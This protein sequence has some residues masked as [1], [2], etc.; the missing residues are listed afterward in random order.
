MTHNVIIGTAGHV[1][2][3]KTWLIKA[4]TGVDTDRLAEEKKRGITIELGFAS[5]PNDEGL[6]IGIIDVPGH[7]K[8]VK[9][10]LAGIGGIDLVLLIIGLDEG[11]MPQTREHFEILKMLRIPKGILVFTKSDLAEE[12]WAAVVEEDAR[13]LVKGSFLEGAPSVRVSALTGENISLLKQMILDGVR[14]TA[15]RRAAPELFRMPVDR[16]FTMEGFGTVA[17]GTLMEGSAAVGEEIMIYPKGQTVRIRGIQNHNVREMEA[18]A[19]QRTA[20][21]LAARKEELDRGDVLARPGG[22]IPGMMADAKVRLFGD[23]KRKLKNNALVHL[24]FGAAQVVAKAVLLDRDVI[25]AGQEAYVQFRFQEPQVMKYGDRF[26]IRF[27]SPV[28]T[29]GGGEFLSAAAEKHR[30]NRPEVLEGLKIRESGTPEERAAEEVRCCS[31]HFPDRRELSV[32]LNCTEEEAAM[33]LEELKKKK[34]I[35]SLGA[36][37]YLH[38]D[39]WQG[40]AEFAEKTVREFHR[41]NPI[42]PGMEREELK[43]R[44]GQRYQAGPEIQELLVNELRKR[45]ALV[46]EGSAV[47][48]ERFA[49]SYEGELLRMKAEI[50]EVY[51]SAGIAVPGSSEM[52]RR[53]K[54]KKMVKQILADLAKQ[55]ILVKVNPDYYME[56]GAWERALQVLRDKIASDGQITLAE[57]RDLLST[58]RKYSQMLLESFDA[59]K[60]TKMVGEAGEEARILRQ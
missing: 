19:G 39:F 36:D 40:I 27:Y 17:T 1:D 58:S 31:G 51:R 16:V 33:L 44:L 56:T 14:D 18:E 50:E 13:E 5:L 22:L 12:D 42:L 54:D 37:R 26:I 28:E 43:T 32:R 57:F 30:R 10:M 8:F 38:Q 29:F 20:L 53:F 23:T 59:K 46:T 11:V 45:T 2:H 9:N 35:I 41:K 21:N 49:S 34:R 6:T 55:G 4:L 47:A 25:G 3:G 52:I 7:E 24:N 15:E 48:L 60:Y